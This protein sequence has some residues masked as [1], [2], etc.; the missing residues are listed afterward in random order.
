MQRLYTQ[1][2]VAQLSLFQSN[3]INPMCIQQLAEVILPPV[4]KA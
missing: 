3:V 2:L 1:A 4:Q